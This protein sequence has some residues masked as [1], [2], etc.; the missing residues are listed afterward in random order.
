MAHNIG[1]PHHRTSTPYLT[2]PVRTSHPC[3]FTARGRTPGKHSIGWVGPRAGLDDMEKGQLM[4]LPGLE[5][6]LLGHTAVASHLF[7]LFH[8]FFRVIID[9]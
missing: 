4:S 2:L 3:R 9:P 8:F 6:W 5:L 1:H 7:I